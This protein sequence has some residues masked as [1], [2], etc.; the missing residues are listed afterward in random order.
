[1]VIS[2]LASLSIFGVVTGDPTNFAILYT[3]GNIITIL[4]YIPTLMTLTYQQGLGF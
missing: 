4:G 2:F 3:L 1:M